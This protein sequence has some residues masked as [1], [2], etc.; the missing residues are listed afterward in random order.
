MRGSPDSEFEGGIYH[1][2]VLLPIDYPL[3]P[4]DIVFLTV[5]EHLPSE[6]EPKDAL[7]KWK[8]CSWTEDMLVKLFLS[9]REL[10]ACLE[11]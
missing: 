8:V 2:R 5:R 9:S 4:P 7:A 6:K 3:K 11:Q 1:G 10:A